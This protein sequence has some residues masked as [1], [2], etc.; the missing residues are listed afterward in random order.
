MFRGV[1]RERTGHSDSWANAMGCCYMRILS[2]NC[3]ERLYPPAASCVPLHNNI[4]EIHSLSYG[5][6]VLKRAVLYLCVGTVRGCWWYSVFWYTLS[7]RYI[8][9]P[10]SGDR[11]AV[12]RNIRERC[13]GVPE[14]PSISTMTGWGDVNNPCRP[15]TLF[16]CF[17]YTLL[18]LTIP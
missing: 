11:R 10:V 2:A 16:Q 4:R 1:T 6:L 9:K 7:F 13:L 14:L 15:R 18:G 17:S 8:I 5:D 12:E 3:N